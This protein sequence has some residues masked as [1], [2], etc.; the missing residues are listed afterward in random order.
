[1]QPAVRVASG[2][3][4][5]SLVL[6]WA[7]TGWTDELQKPERGKKI[8]VFL[9]AGQS[10]ME[11]RADGNK[12]TPQDRERLGKA[13]RRVQLAFNYEP[14]R[15][16]DVA[17]PSAEI[18]EIYKRDLIFG[19]ELFF[20]ITLSEAWPQEKILL[21]KRAEG[22]TSLHGCWNPDW[23]ADKATAMGESGKPK[24][25]SAL[26]AYVKQELSGYGEDEYE[27]CAML[28]V[29]GESDAGNETAAAEYGNNLGNLVERI[30]HDVGRK[31][32]PFLLFQVGHGKV[33]EGMRR[34]AREVPNVT[35]IPQSLDPVSLDFYEKMENGHYN[36]EGMRKLG[37]RFAELFLSQHVQEHE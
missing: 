24:L 14:I 36:H 25:Y 12:L 13:Q 18:A 33:V 16:L 22:G 20:G 7:H 3:L 32:L 26:T 28:W 31:T 34:T 29:Q 6:A 23:R 35:L 4:V 37:H 9:L 30:R 17:K 19:P 11:G 10:N 5:L 8:K 27:I 1:M 15:A 21:I 2:L